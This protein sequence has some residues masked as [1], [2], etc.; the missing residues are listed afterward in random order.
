MI[1]LVEVQPRLHMIQAQIQPI[2]SDVVQIKESPQ[3]GHVSWHVLPAINGAVVPRSGVRLDGV[4]D[5][6]VGAHEEAPGKVET[7]SDSMSKKDD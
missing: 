7:S 6:H 3:N 1:I 2:Q 5:R 4:I